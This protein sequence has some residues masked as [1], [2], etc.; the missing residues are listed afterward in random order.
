ML[1]SKKC[2]IVVFVTRDWFGVSG[3][4]KIT[5]LWPKPMSEHYWLLLAPVHPLKVVSSFHSLVTFSSWRTRTFSS[6]SLP[7]GTTAC[8]ASYRWTWCFSSSRW[9]G[10][11]LLLLISSTRISF[12]WYFLI[13][14]G[15]S[16][17]LLINFYVVS[18]VQ[19]ARCGSTSR[20]VFCWLK[21]E[22]S[23]T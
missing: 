16:W 13:R 22:N 1:L 14:K 21:S 23:T 9:V 5:V 3:K 19:N 4:V 6:C 15:P 2:V 10:P 7:F 11:L 18:L 17:P 8:Q 12:L 20:T